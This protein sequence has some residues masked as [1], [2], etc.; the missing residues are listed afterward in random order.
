MTQNTTILYTDGGFVF[1]A[2]KW[3]PWVVPVLT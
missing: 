1:D 3:A 2:A